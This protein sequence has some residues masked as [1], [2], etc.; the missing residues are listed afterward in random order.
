MTVRFLADE[1]FRT[2]ILAGLRRCVEGVDIVRVQDV[3]LVMA[4]DPAVL[5]WA[6][7]QDRVLVTHD[8]KT[9][10]GFANERIAAGLAM[11]GVL[12]VRSVL[13]VAVAINEL[14]AIAVASE[15]EEWNN[16]VVY[17]PLR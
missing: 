12:L 10:P 13:P 4:T 3:G 9:V 1:N 17:L 16:H 14:A 7:E 15:T 11:P 5:Q 8:L 2:P 6:A